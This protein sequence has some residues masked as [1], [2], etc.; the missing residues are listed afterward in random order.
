MFKK[1]SMLIFVLLFVFAVSMP[2]SAEIKIGAILARSGPASFLGRPA[3]MTLV[4]LVEQINQSGGVLGKKINLINF[5]SRG[6]PDNA[7]ALAKRLVEQENVL[8]IIGPS[9][10][11]ESMKIKDFMNE[12]ETILIS[13]AAGQ[14]IVEP[15][16]KWVFKTPQ[17]DIDAVRRI[18]G[19]MRQMNIKRIAIMASDSGFGLSGK[20]F[21]ENLSKE[22]G[23]EIVISEVYNPRSTDLTEELSR[24]KSENVQAIVNWA[25][26][27]AQG[28]IARNMAQ[29]GLDINLFQSH[30]YGN[31]RY[32]EM[33]GEYSN[34]VIFP[35][36]RLLVSEVLE[37]EHPQKE[38]LLNYKNDYESR[39]R[40]DASAFGGH[41][42]DA[43]MLIIDAIQRANSTEK[44]EVRI[45]LEQTKN[46][47]GSAGIFNMSEADHCGLSK[48][49]FEMIIVKDGRFQ[50]FNP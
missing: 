39:F 40:E 50:I 16:A 12:K 33:S 20:A 9:T 42:Y 13:C 6:N 35:A 4:M 44:E 3:D 19:T 28:L 18:Y 2:L 34:G 48:E 38:V 49:A 36:G 10:T 37:D 8:A 31:I 7:L 5:D 24:I 14:G 45:A 22:Y 43:F 29:I 30:G 47:I 41:A 26:E 46:F 11:G 23:I 17:N 21:L 32:V 25:I 1:F 15:V 27:P